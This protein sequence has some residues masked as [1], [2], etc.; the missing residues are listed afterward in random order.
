MVQELLPTWTF[1]ATLGN[2]S[3]NAAAYEIRV[4]KNEY[5]SQKLLKPLS[6]TYHY[7]HFA[8]IGGDPLTVLAGK[9]LMGL[10]I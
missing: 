8:Q 10:S 2:I 6:H 4:Y 1:Q 3:Y 9:I 7:T 5:S